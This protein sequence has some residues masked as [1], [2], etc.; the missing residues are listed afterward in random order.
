MKARF[1]PEK[2]RLQVEVRSPSEILGYKFRDAV[3]ERRAL[4]HTCEPQLPLCLAS[5]LPIAM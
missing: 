5:F 4:T 1:V 3:L 2:R